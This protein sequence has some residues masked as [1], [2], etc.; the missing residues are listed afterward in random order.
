MPQGIEKN[1]IQFNYV[2]KRGFFRQFEMYFHIEYKISANY[3]AFGMIVAEKMKTKESINW[4]EVIKDDNF[5]N[6]ATHIGET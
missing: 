4:T 2:I 1:L 6:R 3:T 5:F